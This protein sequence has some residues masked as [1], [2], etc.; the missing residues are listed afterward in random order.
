M[1]MGEVVKGIIVFN[2]AFWLHGDTTLFSPKHMVKI[3]GQLETFGPIANLFPTE[4]R[5]MVSK[6]SVCKLVCV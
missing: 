4:V 1:F 6:E 3:T 5:H 2:K